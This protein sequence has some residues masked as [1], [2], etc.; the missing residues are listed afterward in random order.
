MRRQRYA[1]AAALCRRQRVAVSRHLRGGAGLRHWYAGEAGCRVWRCAADAADDMLPFRDAFVHVQ[2]LFL[3]LML[4]S[5][6][7]PPRLI[8][9]A[10]RFRRRFR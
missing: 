9:A 10:S 6:P 4:F 7:L 8:F 5:P 3:I 2:V 1:D